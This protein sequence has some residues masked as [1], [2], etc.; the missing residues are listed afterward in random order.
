MREIFPPT[1]ALLVQVALLAQAPQPRP[2]AEKPLDV[3]FLDTEGGQATLFVSPYGE[4]MLVDTGFPGNQGLPA[5]PSG[6][7]ATNAPQI[8]RDADRITS[9]LKL[10]N[11]V[12][13]DYVIIT[14]YHG[15]H[16]GNAAELASRI[17]IRHF[18]D[19]GPYT[20]ELQ[21]NRVAAFA[22]YQA[23]RD[24]AHAI[25]AKPGDRIPVAGLDV[26]V[27]SS[28]GELITRPIEGAPGAG[29]PN[30][31]CRAAKP[32]DQDPTPE[33]FESVGIVVQYGNFRLLDLGDLTWNQENELVCP[34]NL[35]GTF[36]VFHT[37]RHGDPHAGA[38]Q[39]VHAIR[40]R[41]AVMNNGERKGGD[42][43]YWQVVHEAPGL[44][45]FWQLHRSAAGGSD[46]N[47]PEAFL[48]NLN[49]VDH[50]H[51]L[52][53]SARPDGSFT[54]TNERNG[55]TQNYLAPSNQAYSSP[56]K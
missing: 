9:V 29:A 5:A 16:A 22:S 55:F 37:T 49:E 51:Y 3:Y 52:K 39:L 38:P 42:P 48:A 27:V 32:K 12:V 26:R 25:T 47:S 21:P 10:A 54:M 41:A 8:T 24:K 44:Q 56:K 46:H 43:E 11:I 13:L 2:P 17:P 28:A 40:A 7:A 50:G 1:I 34:S 36:A 20:V 15:D 19:H 18:I 14:H 23:V 33:N 6:A 4:S 35:I 53:M 31:L 45:D 30:P